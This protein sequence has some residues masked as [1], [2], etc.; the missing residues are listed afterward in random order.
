MYGPNDNYNIQSS[1]V[2]PALIKKCYLAKKFN[3]E[4]V[5]NGS[6]KALRQFLYVD[7]FAKIL[8]Q[9]VDKN[10][11]YDLI[12][13]PKQE[14]SIKNIVNIIA[15]Y[16]NYYNIK[17]NKNCN[18]G[19]LKKTASDERFRKFFPCFKFTNIFDG[20]KITIDDFLIK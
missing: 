19:Q 10:I 8:I 13:T 1:H 16:F 6:G 9:M 14:Y 11:P 5:V 4:F 12:I 20:I 2:I 15:K 3:K 7:D 18:E 17:Y